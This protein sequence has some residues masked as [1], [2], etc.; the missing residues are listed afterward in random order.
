MIE[1]KLILIDG[2]TGSGKSTTAQFLFDQIQRNGIEVSWYHEDE[3]DHPIKF[4]EE[5]EV[6]ESQA[7]LE[8]F[9]DTMPR[10]WRDFTQQTIESE[11][12]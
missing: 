6:F 11:S 5:L 12:V 2:I 10:L 3:T 4:D 1:S 7:Q 8:R 9:L